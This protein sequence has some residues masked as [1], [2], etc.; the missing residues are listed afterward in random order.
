[1]FTI[2]LIDYLNTQPFQRSLAARLAGREVDFVRGVPTELNRALFAGDIHLAPI[3][4]I[5][6]ARHA[7][8]VLVLPGLGIA[9]RG[10]VKTVLLFSWR[11]DMRELADKP[12][13]LTDQSATSSA[14]LQWLFRERF[15]MEAQWRKRPQDL[16]AMMKECAA[17]LLIGDTALVEGERRHNLCHAAGTQARP[18]VFDLGEEWLRETGLPFVFALWAV[19]REAVA[20]MMHLGVAQALSDSTADGLNAFDAIAAEYAPR[21]GLPVAVCAGYLRALRF[22]LDKR[23]WQGLTRFLDGVLGVQRE[24]LRLLGV[25]EDGAARDGALGAVEYELCV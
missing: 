19:R 24:A 20:E 23:D 3:S 21:L 10:A 15:G 2:G 17:A 1:M 13:A 4:S 6:A 8:E 14:L 16:V 7:G 12:I 22:H 5:E 11:A 25:G 18:F 9:S